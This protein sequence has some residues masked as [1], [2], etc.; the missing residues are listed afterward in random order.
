MRQEASWEGEGAWRP[1]NGAR[2]TIDGACRPTESARPSMTPDAGAASWLDREQAVFREGERARDARRPIEGTRPPTT[3]HAGPASVLTLQHCAAVREGEGALRTRRASFPLSTKLPGETREE[4]QLL[5]LCERQTLLLQPTATATATAVAPAA[6]L[7]AA[8]GL[9]LGLGAAARAQGA[10]SWIASAGGREL[11]RP[12]SGRSA[13]AS[14]RRPSSSK[15][16]PDSKKRQ[17]NT[18]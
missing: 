7:G 4:R 11:P 15:L 1:T 13:G 16:P 17:A 6:A 5:A 2:H 14:C 3:P 12:R 10:S 18:A 9:G 8:A